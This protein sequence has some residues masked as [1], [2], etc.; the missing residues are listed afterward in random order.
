MANGTNGNG[1]GNGNGLT[2]KQAA[3]VREYL[4]DLN[5]TQAATRAGYSKK[6]AFAIGHENLKKPKIAE[7]IA[8]AMAEQAR[9]TTITADRV[10]QELARIG[11]A[12]MAE[13]MQVQEDGSA[14]VDLSGLNADRGAAIREVTSDTV[15]EGKGEDAVKVMR[16]KLKLHPRTRALELLGKHLGLFAD[17][18]EVTGQDGGPIVTQIERVIVDPSSEASEE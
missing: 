8:K 5:A 9:R 15:T 6:T 10:L 4:V 1:N 7:A 17:R 11:F 18:L 13:F 16:T 2:A 14:A 3:F 12:N